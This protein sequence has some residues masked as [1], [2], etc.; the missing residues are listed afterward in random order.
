M[1]NNSM[2][3]EIHNSKNMT[4]SEVLNVLNEDSTASSGAETNL[5]SRFSSN[6][7]IVA[8]ALVHVAL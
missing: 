1:E 6:S 4:T 3:L 7:K 5:V 2:H 8:A